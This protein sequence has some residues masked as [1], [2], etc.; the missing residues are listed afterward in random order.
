[1]DKLTESQI[2]IKATTIT[3]HIEWIESILRQPDESMP[4]EEKKT[5][6]KALF[7]D[8]ETQAEEGFRIL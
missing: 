6:I 5:L 4:P 2:R 8:I 7:T 1:M 3:S